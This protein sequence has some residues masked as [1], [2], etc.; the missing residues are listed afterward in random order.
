MTRKPQSPIYKGEHAQGMLFAYDDKR[1]LPV[2]FAADAG[3]RFK[4][5]IADTFDGSSLDGAGIEP[6][7]SVVG[8][9]S[10][11]FTAVERGGQITLDVVR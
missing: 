2:K 9:L 6:G 5:F 4:E 1:I 11:E 7:D 3:E 10:V 8:M